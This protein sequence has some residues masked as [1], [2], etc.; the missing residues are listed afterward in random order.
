MTRYT[1]L[2]YYAVL[3]AMGGLISWQLSNLIGLSLIQ[4]IYL[5]EVIVGGL[6]GLCFG[7]LIGLAEG[8]FVRSATFALRAGLI[9]GGLG[10]VAGAIGL[11]LSEALFLMLGGQPWTRVIGWGVFGALVGLGV[12][13]TGGSQAWKPALGGF[14][15]GA[16]GGALLEV[17]NRMFANSLWGKAVGLSLLGAALGVFIALIVL[18]L[19]RAWLE[20][21]SGKLKGTEF[22]LDKFVK[23]GGPTAFIGSDALKSDIVLPDPG[24]DPQHA[25]LSGN[26]SHMQI[27]DMS[28]SGTYV[29]GSKVEQTRL[30][31]K[32]SIRVGNTGLVYHEK[33][34]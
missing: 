6:I 11:P 30:G 27:K 15:G 12:G 21:T 2:Y 18:L 8:L 17:A 33:R 28:L 3:G 25:L 34:N 20:V 10:F 13:I 14:I 16:L 5:S 4:N 31:N 19:S 26:D 7:L 9:S 23:A 1:R 32:Q 22:I 24:V 29:N